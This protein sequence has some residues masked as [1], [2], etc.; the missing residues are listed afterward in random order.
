MAGGHLLTDKPIA[1]LAARRV[2]PRACEAGRAGRLPK[3][4][5]SCYMLKVGWSTR[6]SGLISSLSTVAT[7]AFATS[8]CCRLSPGVQCDRELQVRSALSGLDAGQ[9]DDSS[10]QS[11]EKS[12]TLTPPDSA[13]E[14]PADSAIEPTTTD[15]SVSGDASEPSTRPSDCRRS[16]GCSTGGGPDSIAVSTELPTTD[17]TASQASTQDASTWTT[18]LPPDAG[19]NLDER[20]GN[21]ALGGE[22]ACDDGNTLRGDGCD[23][24]CRQEEGWSCSVGA[25]CVEVC[26]DGSLVGS[27]LVAGGCDDANKTAGDGCDESCR[28]EAGFSC[29]QTPQSCQVGCGDG[30]IAGPEVCDDG[31][32]AP[33]D[34]CFACQL[35][36]G[37]TCNSATRG[38]TCQVA[39]T[40]DQAVYSVNVCGEKG[41][42]LAQC[43]GECVSGECRCV[44]HV[45]TS[46]DDAKSGM[47]WAEAKLTIEAALAA[48]E[49]GGCEVWVAAGSYS[50]PDVG[51]EA[52]FGLRPGV[53][54][55]GGFAGTEVR[56]STRDWLAYETILDGR[57][58]G[59]TETSGVFHVVT[60]ADQALMDG[61][62]VI[63]GNAAGGPSGE[64][65]GGGLFNRDATL[66][67]R[68]TVFRANR[69]EYDGA[70]VCNLAGD[71]TLESVTVENSESIRFS[72][73]GVQ[74]LGVYNGI[75]ALTLRD[76]IVRGHKHSFDTAV[77]GTAV[78]NFGGVVAL[79]GCE[80]TGNAASSGAVYVSA[81]ALLIRQ[82]KFDSNSSVDGNLGGAVALASGSAAIVDSVFVNNQTR[83]GARSGG[84][85][86]LA[87]GATAFIAN[88]R[89]VGN[90]AP[91]QGGAIHNAGELTVSN[92]LFHQNI[93][94]E[95]SVSGGGP[96]ISNSGS[97]HV[98]NCT[99]VGNV[100]DGGGV[101][102]FQGTGSGSVANS[103]FWDNAPFSAPGFFDIAASEENLV[104]LSNNTFGVAEPCPAGWQCP[105]ADPLFEWLD[106]LPVPTSPACVNAGDPS[107][108]P[109]D[110]ADLDGDG[111][112][113][114]PIPFDLR[115]QA[116]VQGVSI[117]LGAIETTP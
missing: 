45:T 11:A 111:D 113:V 80:I 37:V 47:T 39:D 71:L 109:S 101:I 30:Q 116:R 75:G 68:N 8:S 6:D 36:P 31:N 93:V 87:S 41:D 82:T 23:E 55:Y 95:Y 29:G 64:D 103:I 25:G 60:G 54:I 5:R 32:A 35:E 19:T 52:T 76:S 33:D 94:T 96:A 63:G 104:Q 26:G 85:I 28:V 108:L 9:L 78:A 74:G 105:I 38:S 84:A 21:G 10:T 53:A 91:S 110:A 18:G 34:G 1:R 61:F 14:P 46:G 98:S 12:M 62:T 86:A 72:A 7:I 73:M 2:L 90:S 114:E 15:A 43:A 79:N 88:T 17:G 50:T 77:K 115:G 3:N 107:A 99:F 67:V 92:A 117:D 70:G 20:C 51:R 40:G 42:I 102:H 106:D 69:T 44:V 65:C 89:F 58:D 16:D 83:I 27:E 13:I 56:R 66:T 59:V 22:E 81:G 49:A 112:T 100:A 4:W 57:G 97:L 24:T 48:A